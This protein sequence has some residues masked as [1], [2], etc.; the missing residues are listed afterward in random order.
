MHKMERRTKKSVDLKFFVVE[1]ESLESPKM[2]LESK[3]LMRVSFSAEWTIKTN[4][5]MSLTSPLDAQYSMLCASKI[6]AASSSHLA[7]HTETD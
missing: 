4:S 7:N 1:S 3:S 6:I 2:Q 5:I